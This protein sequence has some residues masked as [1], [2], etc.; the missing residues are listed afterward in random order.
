MFAGLMPYLSFDL[1]NDFDGAKKVAKA[2]TLRSLTSNTE[3]GLFKLYPHYIL[4]L[5]LLQPVPS[6]IGLRVSSTNSATLDQDAEST[7]GCWTS[8]KNGPWVFSRS[9]GPKLLTFG[10]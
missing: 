4:L 10:S 6:T 9:R 1:T 2:K 7:N 3:T 5:L 8:W